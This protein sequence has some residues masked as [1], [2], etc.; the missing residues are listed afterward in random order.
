MW[1]QPDLFIVPVVSVL[2]AG[3]L[4]TKLSTDLEKLDLN[5]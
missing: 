1:R 3:V 4:P 5:S 2:V